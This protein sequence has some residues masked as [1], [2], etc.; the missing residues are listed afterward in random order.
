MYKAKVPKWRCPRCLKW[1]REPVARVCE[2]C[3]K[4]GTKSGDASSKAV[5]K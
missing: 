2:K 5:Q 3:R 1:K 4:E